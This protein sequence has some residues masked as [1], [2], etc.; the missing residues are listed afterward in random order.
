MRDPSPPLTPGIPGAPTTPR[1]RYQLQRP[2]WSLLGARCRILD[3]H[4]QLILF[5]RRKA[6]RLRE[7]IGVFEDEAETRPALRIRTGSILDLGAVY[8]IRD[9]RTSEVIGQAR[10]RFMRSMIRD[11][12]ELLDRQG[13]PI[14][15]AEE[16]STALALL[17]RLLTN[18]VPQR[19]DLVVGERP[20]GLIRQRFNPFVFRADL[21]I[22]MDARDRI[23]ERHLF[24]LAV[25]L[26][27]VEGRQSS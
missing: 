19:F 24:G 10:R 1:M 7:D 2:L 18:L 3:A 13:R 22:D 17:R 21:E 8:E 16:D 11:R 5:A 6:L 14:G 12:W 9:A 23:D 25:L 15:H 20:I 4:G 26:M 27:V